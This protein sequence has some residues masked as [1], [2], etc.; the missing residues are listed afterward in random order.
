MKEHFSAGGV[1]VNKLGKVY[2]IHKISRDEW[3]LPK[4]TIEKDEEILDAATRE[5]G[6]ETG[7]THITPI[8]DKPLKS[9]HYVMKHPSTGEDID[10][11]V[12]YFAF[13]LDEDTSMHTKEM[14]E[15]D[16]EGGWFDIDDAIDKVSFE[17]LKEV[18]M[19]FRQLNAK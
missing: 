17:N 4:G 3:A 7:Y 5:I 12:Y 14:E 18:L 1:L 11:T 13:Q 2:L 10:K 16:L 6:E 8:T 15:E 9:D 19:I